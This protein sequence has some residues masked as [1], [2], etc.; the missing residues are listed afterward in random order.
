MNRVQAIV[1]MML[2]SG[3]GARTLGRLIDRSQAVGIPL[4]EI[5]EQPSDVL[6]ADFDLRPGV[7]ESLPGMQEQAGQIV[8]SLEEHDI[9]MLTVSD[10]QYPDRLTEVL[11]H[12]APPV[13]FT[14]GNAEILEHTA[15]T[16]SG[17]RRAE[18]SILR[19]VADLAGRLA[20]DS[21]NIVSGLAP[22]VDMAAHLAALGAGG[23]T[24]IV[25][26]GGILSFRPG[27]ELAGLLSE[28]NYLILSEFLP[29]ASWSMGGAMTRNQTM[30]GLAHMVVLAQQGMQGGTFEMGRIVLGHGL[31]L[32][33]LQNDEGGL[34]PGGSGH[35]VKRGAI[36]IQV[37]EISGLNDLYT[38][39]ASMEA[40]QPMQTPPTLFGDKD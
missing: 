29:T 34:P 32:F 23:V 10:N 1:Q 17:S 20:R 39:S 40:G 38:L 9:R 18:D 35:F 2:T 16:F 14:Q 36:A 21:T 22:G 26:A 3:L 4:T 31:P 7:A 25:L 6:I 27:S 5:V 13:L 33:V 37:S 30:A 24:T 12:L 15:M 28:D 19:S 11:G 8:E